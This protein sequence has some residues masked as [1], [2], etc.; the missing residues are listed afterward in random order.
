MKINLTEEL[1][2]RD[3]C[4]FNQYDLLN[5][6]KSTKL[7]ESK[8]TKLVNMLVEGK[9]NREISKIF[10]ED[11][12]DDTLAELKSKSRDTWTED[13]LETYRYCDT[14]LHSKESEHMHHNDAIEDSYEADGIEFDSD[15]PDIDESVTY[16]DADEVGFPSIS[17]DDD[18]YDD[19]DDLSNDVFFE[20]G[21]EY[22]LVKVLKTAEGPDAEGWIDTWQVI[23]AVNTD[24]DEHNYFVRTE[25]GFV[26]W[27][28]VDTA[29]EAISWLDNMWSDVNNS[30]YDDDY[31]TFDLDID[32][33]Y[34]SEETE[35]NH[36]I[37]YELNGKFNSGFYT[38]RQYKDLKS[39]P[40]VKI[41]SVE[42]DNKGI[43]IDEGLGNIIK[44]TAKD[45][46]KKIAQPFVKAGQKI[47]DVAKAIKTSDTISDVK[48]TLAN[49]KSE[50]DAKNT[51]STNDV[52]KTI[53][54]KNGTV[55]FKTDKGFFFDYPGTTI[56]NKKVSLKTL[57]SVYPSIYNAFVK[58]YGPVTED[59]SCINKK[60]K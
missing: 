23:D 59:Y 16:D 36:Y 33:K 9:S 30:S 1:N 38:A 26:D 20:D 43:D 2:K 40:A 51:K 39:S 14:T 34:V 42:I 19:Y 50:R 25:D 31:P 46:G 24:T 53:K 22:K 54:T 29:D 11:W 27:G 3:K 58:K 60:I 12:C 55:L 7:S 21:A 15:A 35:K 5:T 4:S 28:P 10:E 52:R 56:H 32:E 17:S 48:K 37:E 6:Y 41:L 45:V 57:Q 49:T 8:K 47:S 44:N 13:D 18:D